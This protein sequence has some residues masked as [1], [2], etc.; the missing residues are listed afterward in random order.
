[1]WGEWARGPYVSRTPTETDGADLA[2]KP[3]A[4]TLKEM[5]EGARFGII[6]D[7]FDEFIQHWLDDYPVSSSITKDDSPASR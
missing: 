4:L 1:M 6:P 2:S 3:S 7:P 5:E